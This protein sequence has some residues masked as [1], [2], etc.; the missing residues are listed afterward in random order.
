M[1]DKTALGDR[2]KFYESA[3]INQRLMP[4][5]PAF[6]RIDGKGFHNWTKGLE[7]PYDKTFSQIMIDVTKMLVEDTQA[8]IGYTQS[9]EI[10]LSWYSE[11]F[12]SQIYFDGKISKIISVVAS[13]TTAYFNS[14]V[15][16]RLAYTNKEAAFFDCRVW[17]VPT[18]WEASNVFLWREQDATRNSIQMAARSV[19]SHKQCDNKN[20]NELQ[21]MLFQK[22]IN[23]NNYPDSFKR[24]TYILNH[25][26]TT[27]SKIMLEGNL[28]V[29]STIENCPEVLYFGAE[30]K[31]KINPVK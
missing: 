19:Y 1:S 20:M 22:N 25:R 23:W 2:M 27:G 13:M 21:E 8:V 12:K 4:Q 28:P 17:N 6:A 11:D 14:L 30:P 7:R 15:A 24:G 26:S 31:I 5:L 16:Q 29:L 18:L 10:T 3:F 9:D